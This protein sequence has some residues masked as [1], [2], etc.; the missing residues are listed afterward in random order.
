MQFSRTLDRGILVQRYKR[1]F[2][3]VALDD[4]RNI[5][6]HC[7]NPGAMLGIK[8]P[9]TPVWLSRSDSKTR[10]LAHTLEIVEADGA[11]IGANTMLPNALTAEALAQDV[12]PELSGY[13]VH[14]REVK[15]GV[16]SR[17]DFVL[18][19]D[20][21]PP[22][23]LEVKNCHLMRAGALAEFPDCVTTR[24][25]KHLDD[26]AREVQ[27]GHRAVL[28]FVIQRGDCTAFEAAAD[29][30]PAYAA[31][32]VTAAREGVEILCYACDI[33]LEAIRLSHR[34]PWRTAL[35]EQTA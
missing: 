21:R 18:E 26:L 17:V 6:A 5:T 30:D 14:R 33:T 8:A 32:L 16:G 9:G 13:D 35:L 15:Y 2:V 29:L 20:G 19:S 34:I 12:I 27:A 22:C 28:L 24:G 23:Y 1:F 25:L 3:D 10:K 31:R 4:G 11:L 7:A